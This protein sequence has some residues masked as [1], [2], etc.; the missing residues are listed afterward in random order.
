MLNHTILL[1][2]NSHT[3]AKHRRYRGKRTVTVY[4]QLED[5]HK[6]MWKTSYSTAPLGS[7]G[8]KEGTDSVVPQPLKLVSAEGYT[9]ESDLLERPR[10]RVARRYC[11]MT[12]L[13]F[14]VGFWYLNRRHALPRHF[15]LRADAVAIR[16]S[17]F[18]LYSFLTPLRLL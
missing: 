5:R 4:E 6:E 8:W 2:R 17:A 13:F 3:W 16:G 10:G 1:P 18:T 9:N 11:G 12:V 15:I 14:P 7:A